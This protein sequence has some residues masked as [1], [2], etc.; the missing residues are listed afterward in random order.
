[1]ETGKFDVRALFEGPLAG[2]NSEATTVNFNRL[3]LG[4]QFIAKQSMQER[5][6]SLDEDLPHH[7]EST[8]PDQEDQLLKMDHGISLGAGRA[9]SSTFM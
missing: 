7:F 6:Q 2:T 9:R 3:P 1:M 4:L 8:Q 5:R